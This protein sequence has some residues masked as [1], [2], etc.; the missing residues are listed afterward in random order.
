MTYN[1]SFVYNDGIPASND[2]PS[3]DQPIIL[4]NTQT[5]KSVITV[6]HFGFQTGNDGTHIHT[7]FTQP[8]SDPVLGNSMTQMYPKTFGPGPTLLETYMAGKT[9]GG[10]QINGY[11]PFVKCMGRYIGIAG[12][13]A[14]APIPNTIN[15][16]IASVVQNPITAIT[17]TFIT[18]LP[19]T[20][21]FVFL[22][23]FNFNPPNSF[24]VQKF[25]NFF[26]ILR[27]SNS[28]NGVNIGFMVI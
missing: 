3:V 20:T 11:S 1:G 13:G 14:I 4:T 21:Y 19:T 2:S 6:D 24:S 22:E 26:Q 17:V 12:T 18:P 9:N 5:L 10:S 7:T 8:Q 28:W 23:P 25:T 16:N 27:G 15:V